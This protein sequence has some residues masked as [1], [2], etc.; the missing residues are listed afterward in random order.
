LNDE[1]VINNTKLT[2][3]A[4]KK[5]IYVGGTKEVRLLL[6]AENL[7]SIPPN[8][9]LLVIRDGDKVYQVNFTADMQTNASIV[10]KRK[11]N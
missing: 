2:S 8:T 11:G 4:T 7:G 3:V 6:V 9:G 1:P 5:T 10:L